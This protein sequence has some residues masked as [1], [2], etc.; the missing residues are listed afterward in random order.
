MIWF[1]GGPSEAREWLES[2]WRGAWTP[3]RPGRDCRPFW[4]QG[5][6]PG[7]LETRPG[8]MTIRCLKRCS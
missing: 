7:P 5:S 2:V 1:L 8:R 6:H 3:R 4:W